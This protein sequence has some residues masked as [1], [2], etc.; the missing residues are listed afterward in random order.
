MLVILSWFAFRANT[1]DSQIEDMGSYWKL[2]SKYCVSFHRMNGAFNFQSACTKIKMVQKVMI[3][4]G[5]GHF[6]CV[7]R[8]YSTVVGFKTSTSADLS[9]QPSQELTT[10]QGVANASRD[11]WMLEGI[12][13]LSQ[14]NV[15]S[16]VNFQSRIIRSMVKQLFIKLKTTS[17]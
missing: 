13:E 7:T 14:M 10:F 4:W 16:R 2:L 1:M 6:P 5:R 3:P 11:H 9:Y 8:I 17:A 12:L 15:K